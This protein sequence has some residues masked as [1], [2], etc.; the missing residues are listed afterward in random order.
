MILKDPNPTT[1]KEVIEDFAKHS[2]DYHHP[3]DDTRR[4]N[5]SG[6]VASKDL[7]MVI[8]KARYYGLKN[9]EDRPVNPCYSSGL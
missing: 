5:M 1:M 7:M 8:M 9:H 6:N 3:Q 2:R 4:G